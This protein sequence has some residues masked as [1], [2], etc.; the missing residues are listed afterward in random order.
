MVKMLVW[1]LTVVV[2]SRNLLQ[3]T[4]MEGLLLSSFYTSGKAFK[5]KVQKPKSKSVLRSRPIC[6]M[7]LTN[8][9]IQTDNIFEAIKSFQLCLSRI[10]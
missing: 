1:Q 2:D 8:I 3:V 5:D 4:V 10:L 9:D 6:D 7:G